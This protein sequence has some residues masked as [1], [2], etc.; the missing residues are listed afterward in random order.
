MY[1]YN[2]AEY[3][4]ISRKKNLYLNEADY[5]NLMARERTY[6]AEG[7]SVCQVISHG[8]ET[9]NSTAIFT[10][11]YHQDTSIQNPFPWSLY[12]LRLQSV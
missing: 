9:R 5:M 6:E 1:V 3:R 8:Q 7:Y 11:A 12:C 4:T 10:Q 2:Q